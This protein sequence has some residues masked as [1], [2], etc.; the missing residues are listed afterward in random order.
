MIC[1][2]NHQWVYDLRLYHVHRK[3]GVCGVIQRHAWNRESVYTD[4]ETIREDAYV[5]SEQQQIVRKPSTPV[6]R[7][8]HS[9]RLLRRRASDR[10][11]L[12]AR[13]ARP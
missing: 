8:A 13:L 3:C 11:K 7:V 1:L 4:W 5:E 6:V 2:F 12:W 10:R 9:L